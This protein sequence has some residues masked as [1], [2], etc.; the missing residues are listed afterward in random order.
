[1]NNNQRY[2]NQQQQQ[3]NQ[4]YQQPS[5]GQNIY[6][7][8]WPQQGFQSQYQ[9]M[10]QQTNN[11]DGSTAYYAQQPR[12]SHPQNIRYPHNNNRQK[13]NFNKPMYTP[14]FQQQSNYQQKQNWVGKR[15]HDQVEMSSSASSSASTSSNRGETSPAPKRQS[16]KQQNIESPNKSMLAPATPQQIKKMKRKIQLENSPAKIIQ[17]A[18]EAEWK[19]IFT[20]T[21]ELLEGCSPGEEVAILL[22]YLQPSRASWASVKDQIHSDMQNLMAPLGVEKMLVFGSTLTGLDFKGSDLDYHISLNYPLENP[23]EVKQIMNR[24][25]KLARYCHDFRVI[26]SVM[27]ARVPIIRLVHKRTEVTCD[28]NFTSPFGYYNSQFIRTVLGFDARIKELAVILKLWSKSNKIAERMVTSNY[29]LVM[30]LIFYL[31]NLSQPMLDSIKN[32]QEGKTHILDQK[33]KWNFF[34]NDKINKSKQ[35]TQ[36]T[37]E[38]LEGFFEFYHKLNFSDYIVSLYSGD[39]IARKE[40]DGHP[41]LSYYREVI[42]ES[43]LPSIKL[44]NP[45]TFIVQDGFEQNLNIG[46][47]S[48]KHCDLFFIAVKLSHEK[49][50]ELKTA[51]MSTLLIKL[52]TDLKFPE[53]ATKAEVR[54]KKKFQ[55]TIHSVAGDLKVRKMLN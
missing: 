50:L 17:N 36:T 41:D 46:I 53:V 47:K 37:R 12:R 55:M 54:A 11:F 39:L 20:H 43:E 9:Q 28:I 40:F 24:T 31:Q 14:S 52:F 34:F 33:F 26:Y 16:Q 3:G 48:K 45:E 6:N 22:S 18:K 30:L 35:N 32:N 4:N 29:C 10:Q 51:P 19:E 42:A 21:L 38:L 49:C 7:Q 2:Y 23:E 5:H 8:R 44:D 25:L 27:H 13:P 1:M 15:S